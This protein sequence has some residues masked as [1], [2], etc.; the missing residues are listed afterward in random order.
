[1]ALLATILYM[2]FPQTSNGMYFDP[3]T[4]KFGETPLS[5]FAGLSVIIGFVL[6]LIIRFAFGKNINLATAVTWA[7]LGNILGLGFAAISDIWINGYSPTVAV[8]GEFLPA[9]GPN[10]IFA[11]ILV[12]ILVVAYDA[13]QKQT[14]R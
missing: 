4:N 10:M 3:D 14:G 6:V 2:F 7:I 12:P 9:A 13:I 8:V 5:T 11:A 1:L